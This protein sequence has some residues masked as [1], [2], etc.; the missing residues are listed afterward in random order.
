MAGGLS[1]SDEYP[2]GN[3]IGV[4]MHLRKV[5]AY[6]ASLSFGEPRAEFERDWAE[7]KSNVPTWPGFREDRIYG[8]GAR[9]LKIHKYK[10]RKILKDGFD[11]PT[12]DFEG[13]A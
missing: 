11:F 3:E 1:W 2:S 8:L 9:L 7:L 4:A 13:N 5:I 6:R 10:E 12:K